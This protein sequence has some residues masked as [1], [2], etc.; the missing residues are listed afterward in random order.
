MRSQVPLLQQIKKS[1]SNPSPMNWFKT[2]IKTLS[3]LFAFCFSSPSLF[4]QS[5][6]YEVLPRFVDQWLQ[7][8]EPASLGLPENST[9]HWKTGNAGLA[10]WEHFR[11]QVMHQGFK[12]YGA[13]V[14]VHSQNGVIESV[15]GWKGP[16]L[17]DSFNPQIR[18]SEAVQIAQHLFPAKTYAW[19][20]AA[21]ENLLQRVRADESATF[22]PKPELVILPKSLG[23]FTAAYRLVYS[24]ELWHSSPDFKGYQ[25]FIDATSGALLNAIPTVLECGVPAT[26]AS[27]YVSESVSF[28]TDSC[29][30]EFYRLR[31]PN[32]NIETYNDL[33]TQT[34]PILDFSSQDTEWD[35]P[36]HLNGV[37]AHWGMT[38]FYDYFQEELGWNSYDN[39]GSKLF[40]WANYGQYF[41]N[42]QWVGVWANFGP[43]DGVNFGSFTTLD[44]VAHE[45]GHGFIQHT[46]NL[47]PEGEPG[48][49]NEGFCDVIG[50][51]IEHAKH[52]DGGDWQ[53]GAGL[54][55][56][57]CCIRDLQNPNAL[58]FPDTY[59]GQYWADQTDCVASPINDNCHIHRN[60]NVASHF[61]YLLVE[62]GSGTNDLGTVY[63]VA[64]IGM[65]A[66]ASLIFKTLMDYLTP[67]SG[68]YEARQAT[69]FAATELGFNTFQ[70]EQLY[71]AWCAVGIGPCEAGDQSTIGL[72]YPNGNELF[73]S[74]EEV[75]IQ[76]TLDG[77]VPNFSLQFSINEGLSWTNIEEEFSNDG[78][79]VYTWTIP[80]V[81]SPLCKVRIL[82]SDS[83]L[84]SDASDEVF[85]VFGCNALA[86]ITANSNN[87]CVG[88]T[89]IALNTSV[90]EVTEVAWVLD[91][92]TI[93]NNLDSIHWTF[94]TIDAQQLV[95]HAYNGVNCIDTYSWNLQVFATPT[96]EFDV[97][98]IN[99]A[100]YAV[101]DQPNQETYIW[102]LDGLALPDEGPSVSVNEVEVGEHTLC[103]TTDGYC[104]TATIC[105]DVSVSEAV[106]CT[107][108][109]T[110]WRQIFNFTTVN[111]LEFEA[112]H[113]WIAT[114]IGVF[115]FNTL[116]AETDW[117]NM[118]NSGL[119][120]NRIAQ[121]EVDLTGKVWMGA[122]YRG[123][124]TLEDIVWDTLNQSNSWLPNDNINALTFAP[125]GDL[126][127]GTDEGA[128]VFDGQSSTNSFS[129][130]NG[131]EY[132]DFQEIA[133]S[134]DGTAW[135]VTAEDFARYDG[136]LHFYD[137]FNS[138]LTPYHGIRGIAIDSLNGKP[139][140]ATSNNGIFHIN[141]TTWLHFNQDSLVGLDTDKFWDI[142]VDKNGSIWASAFNGN[143]V[144]H[145]QD[146]QFTIESLAFSESVRVY[147]LLFDEE[148]R[149]WAGSTEGISTLLSG[150]ANLVE[151][152]S[153]CLPIGTI[154]D[155]EF[156]G[157]EAIWISTNAGLVKINDSECDVYNT[158]NSLLPSNTILD[159]LVT[160]EHQKWIGTNSGLVKYDDITWS[161]FFPGVAFHS[162]CEGAEGRLWFGAHE[163]I[164]KLEDGIWSS[165][166]D[167]LIPQL[168]DFTTLQIFEDLNGHLWI[169]GRHYVWA[170]TSQAYY[171]YRFD[172]NSFE[173]IDEA[174]G[175]L[176]FSHT[177]TDLEYQEDSIIWYAKS[178]YSLI[179]PPPNEFP[180]V[181]YKYDLGV[182]GVVATFIDTKANDIEFSENGEMILSINQSIQKMDSSGNLDLITSLLPEDW[183]I[184]DFELG[185]NDEIW[186]A[187]G[188]GLRVYELSD[189]L[190]SPSFLT[191]NFYCQGTHIFN[192]TTLGATSFQWLVNENVIS[193]TENLEY[194][195]TDPGDY[196]ITLEATNEN[197]CTTSYTEVITIHSKADI[198]Q[199]LPTIL[200]ICDNSYLFDPEI[201]GMASYAWQL[202]GGTVISTEPS[203][204]ILESGY[205]TLTIED[206]CGQ[207][208]SFTVQILLDDDCVWPGDT[209]SD[210]IVNI[211]DVLKI[212]EA[213]G[214]FG[215][216]RTEVSSFFEGTAAENWTGSFWVEDVNYK[217]ADA[218]GDGWIDINDF[219]AIE[220]NYW[221]IHG[222]PPSDPG[223]DI[224]P[225]SLATRIADV[226][227]INNDSFAVQLEIFFEHEN[228]PTLQSV[229]GVA[230]KLNYDIDG[231]EL[232][233]PP[234]VNYDQS[235]L[236]APWD[237]VLSITR[238]S[239]QQ[240]EIESAITKVN[241]INANDVQVLGMTEFIVI[242]DNIPTGDTLDFIFDI[243]TA[244]VVSNDGSIIPVGA[245][246]Q[247]FQIVGDEVFVDQV[248]Q[249]PQWQVVPN[250][251]QGV[252]HLKGPHQ[253]HNHGIIRVID[254][255]GN[256][257]FNQSLEG[258]V[259][260]YEIDLNDQTSGIY[261]LQVQFDDQV[262]TE[263]L[264]RI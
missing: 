145:M 198:P 46:A 251:S 136:Q 48:A 45:F 112:P 28:M 160:T 53:M 6:N 191:E 210:G 208:E 105:Q 76:W 79:G 158:S 101:A 203:L 262:F 117:Y 226:I 109:A 214:R 73:Q 164:Y 140:L 152:Y 61:F 223:L 78:S 138:P 169:R 217:H 70:I 146:G 110:G 49:L 154:N 43:G 188:L 249:Q 81:N 248:L 252:F 29:V 60:S 195:F 213:Y 100:V 168:T 132:N 126:W 173:E 250:P 261:I 30:G 58:Q 55:L 178:G 157:N 175:V 196:L 193:T 190:I 163:R 10:N 120:A 11:F 63:D 41:N 15:N 91:G 159:V 153:S 148:N 134:P 4:S 241:H 31:D 98:G 12:I 143:Q 263:R 72:I 139:W 245:K 44:V 14:L 201:D 137:E 255:Q 113:L 68:F 227:P 77:F 123:I 122:S 144:Y 7:S 42:A 66:G 206:Y 85:S 232:S 67:T 118:Y 246:T 83:P 257:I 127:V 47:I 84:I 260:S 18:A 189:S 165:Y 114:Q 200:E 35:E 88:E 256:I 124:F 162:S 264:I 239:P 17:N 204:S 199:D 57:D 69:L 243:S 202:N 216:S 90:S 9:L 116:T 34:N 86:H 106:E 50:T 236:G 228:I 205:Y 8:I 89:L 125:N 259:P 133:H 96:A 121:V 33:N 244:R 37:D 240:K 107:G 16:D 215:P 230:F 177:F 222:V 141:D 87:F 238:H 220:E 93:S 39:E 75:E 253:Q 233:S 179:G 104:G 180:G 161:N 218:N 94:D 170:T 5:A 186:A 207:E 235:D 182:E 211:F 38:Q 108:N 99:Q 62:G 150:A 1:T 119:G 219:L 224:S 51:I 36:D 131:F 166:D 56:L 2:N 20:N 92:D 135:M 192:N 24:F 258:S 184:Q 65:E 167:A 74:G 97:L 194:T 115:K 234:I 27:N 185:N 187:T 22:E 156:E 95:L 32:R 172:G 3:L 129:T 254:L 52:P 21:L 155:I 171:I 242:G 237:E 209:N 59:L 181:L 40:A 19:E 103:L 142:A 176:N 229:Y 174:S 26:G 64:G 212:G 25:V 225:I 130:L 111:D 13:E 151:Y 102:T 80:E 183:S 247:T 149:L 221:R 23:N 128:V 54:P 147:T 82:S 231:L 197:D 71:Q